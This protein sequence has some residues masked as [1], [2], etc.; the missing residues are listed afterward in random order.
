MPK[1]SVV[2]PTY[3]RER[4]I[5]RAVESVLAQTFKDYEIILIDDGSTD[6]TKEILRSFE[7][8]IRYIYQTNAGISGAR[9]RG[10]QE[11]SGEYIAFL[12]SDD[13]WLPEKLA[14]QVRILD[15]RPEIGIVYARMPIIN[16]AGK[17]IGLKP[18]AESGKN[19]DEL[20][21]LWGDLPTSTV[22]VRKACFEK[23]GL[24]DTTLPPME[25]IDMW[26][27][28]SRFY[29]LYEIEGKTLA[30]YHYHDDQITKKRAKAYEALIKLY[31]K[32]LRNYKNIP[33]GLMH[34]RIATEQ[35][36][37]SRLYYNEGF[38]KNSLKN[39]LLT[40]IR[41]P[42]VGIYFIE[43][44]DSFVKRTFKFLKP[45]AFLLVCFVRNCLTLFRK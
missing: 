19:F 7:G 11:S 29:G 40:L 34:K 15:T 3:N 39:L 16:E 18:Q 1:V 37:L 5:A 24:F 27:R 8:R 35:Y 10:I 23:A 12:D 33:V 26:I 4:L 25:D 28:I 43:P 36:V 45:F 41:F 6:Q 13:T 38:L 30:L 20:I 31:K 2:I 22:M 17:Q 9:N 42:W 44:Q 32:I 21:R 14:E